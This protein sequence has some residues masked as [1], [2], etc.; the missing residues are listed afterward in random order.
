MAP[1]KGRNCSTRVPHF[2]V[3]GVPEG[4]KRGAETVPVQADAGRVLPWGG[5]LPA[6]GEKKVYGIPPAYGHL[7]ETQVR[8]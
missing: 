6:M 5:V 7:P 1:A 3:T 4:R 2:G 8:G